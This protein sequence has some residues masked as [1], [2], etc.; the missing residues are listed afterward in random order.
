MDEEFA[1]C[2]YACEANGMGGFGKIALTAALL[3][4]SCSAQSQIDQIWNKAKTAATSGN[5]TGNGLS[6]EKIASGLK[7]AL[8]VS[9][10]KAVAETG[11]PDGYFKNQAIKILV[12]DNLRTVSKGMR[13]MGMGAQVDDLELGMNRAAEQAAPE[14]KRIFLNAVT[15]MTFADARQILS[16]N[17]TAATGYFKTHSSAELTEAF[18]PIVHKAME[19]VGVIQ[20]YDRM[21]KSSGA[22]P[23]LGSQKF[24]LDKYVVGKSLDGLFYMLGEE[25]KRIRTNPAAQT[26]TLLKQ[27]FGKK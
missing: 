3:A 10:G 2:H 1:S 9:T 4:G 14:A 15:Q 25:E 24:N 23:F 21:M 22:A 7:E 8:T 18:T 6:N 26:T 12:P 20:Q 27:V 13:L 16:S 11:R 19:N 17:N 5:A